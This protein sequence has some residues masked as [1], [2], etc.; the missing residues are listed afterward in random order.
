LSTQG[1]SLPKKLCLPQWP[2]KAHVPGSCLGVNSFA[3]ASEADARSA[4]APRTEPTCILT[5]TA[6]RLWLGGRI[7]SIQAVE[8][9]RNSRESRFE[10]DSGHRRDLQ[11]AVNVVRCRKMMMVMEMKLSSKDPAMGRTC[12]SAR[13]TAYVRQ[14]GGVAARVILSG[15]GFR[16]IRV[17]GKG[18][19]KML[20]L[21]PP[22]RVGWVVSIYV[23]WSYSSRIP[24]SDMSKSGLKM[25]W[26]R[27]W[28]WNSLEWHSDQVTQR[29]MSQDTEIKRVD[30][31]G[32]IK[33]LM[34]VSRDQVGTYLAVSTGVHWKSSP[35]VIS[36]SDAFP[37]CNSLSPTMAPQAR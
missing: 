22:D 32:F 31:E 5:R 8:I 18:D 7:R 15:A 34:G 19:I 10:T 13:F 26:P 3:P 35:H 27:V 16:F 2:R 1:S 33:C 11:R 4:V 21:S 29:E 36:T 20:G 24:Y 30:S 14:S 23:Y 12:L 9:S 28:T 25:K 37:D 6:R 17:A